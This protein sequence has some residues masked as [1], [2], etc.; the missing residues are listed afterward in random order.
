MCAFDKKRKMSISPYQYEP[1]SRKI[2]DSSWK[3]LSDEEEESE[4]ELE[5][6]LTVMNR[7]SKDVSTW[8][9]CFECKKMP[10]NKECLCC[11]EIDEIRLK[12]LD[13]GKE[14]YI[15]R[16]LNFCPFYSDCYSAEFTCKFTRLS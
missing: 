2:S 7:L 13:E 10:V 8:C 9:K 3:T 11:T 16:L 6:N 14:F 15:L 12:K 4:S 1:K 5:T